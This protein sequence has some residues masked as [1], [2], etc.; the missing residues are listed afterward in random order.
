VYED[1]VWGIFF[2]NGM[3]DD[4]YLKN[5]EGTDHLPLSRLCGV[6]LLFW[7]LCYGL[8]VDKVSD[9]GF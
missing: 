9:S 6:F 5:F 2:G 1:T 8:G 3:I 4:S 7:W